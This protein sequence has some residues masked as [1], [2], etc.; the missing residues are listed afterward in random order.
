MPLLNINHNDLYYESQG[1]GEP[2]ILIAGFACDRLIWTEVAYRLAPR[3]Q[4]IRFDNRGMGKSS[5]AE[6]AA[7]LGQLAD[8]VAALLDMLDIPAAHIAGHSMG[9]MVAQEL[10]LT[11]P[12]KVK[13]LLLL[14]T[15]A[16]SDARG[17]AVIE[18]WGDLPK[19]VD[20]LTMTRILLPWMYTNRFY[21][22]PGAI[23][24]LIAQIMANPNPPSAQAIYDQSR[25]ISSFN[26]VS[27][28]T[29]IHCPTLALVGSDDIVLPVGSSKEL[30]EGISGAELVILEKTGHVLLIE[31]P[32]E[33]ANAM[34]AFLQR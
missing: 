2:L 3:Y 10:A 32:G 27:R 34:L 24:T 21:S 17:Q 29:Q 15:G 7:N 12:E 1:S 26:S 31:S 23:E 11:Y 20:P 16:Q 5:Y 13:S 9:G 19:L 6:P 25:A 28:L 18:L 22:R 4:V 8:D 14:S 30:V 33:V